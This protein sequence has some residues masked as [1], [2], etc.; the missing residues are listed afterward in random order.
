MFYGIEQ[1]T[2]LKNPRTV[3]KKT[4]SIRQLKLWMKKNNGRF[5][6]DD[7]KSAN[8]YHHTFRYGYEYIGRINKKHNIFNNR[9]TNTYPQSYEDN[10]YEYLYKFGNEIEII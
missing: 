5:T 1:S 8:N 9:G 4:Q 2:D 10:L 3:I 7:P 6:Y